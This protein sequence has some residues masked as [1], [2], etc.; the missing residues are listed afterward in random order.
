MN[1]LEVVPSPA[2]ARK[3]KHLTSMMNIHVD[4][5]VMELAK[6]DIF[7]SRSF[8]NSLPTAFSNIIDRKYESVVSFAADTDWR[9]MIMVEQSSEFYQSAFLAA[10]ASGIT[11]IVLV[12]P[13]RKAK[14]F[15]IMDRMLTL[16]NVDYQLVD[17]RFSG[18]N[19]D[20]LVVSP[21]KITSEVI[22][23]TR[24]GIFV[25]LATPATSSSTLD[26]MFGIKQPNNP[27]IEY[28]AIGMEFQHLI[29]GVAMDD[30]TPHV[31]F[32]ADRTKGSGWS[33]TREF[34]NIFSALFPE[35]EM[36]SFFDAYQN[37]TNS[38]VLMKSG[39]LLTSPDRF[40]TVLNINTDLLK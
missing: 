4:D 38:N 20:V 8:F 18:V 12:L 15:T 31:Y 25:S 7:D 23:H 17:D 30:C 13:D 9:C 22:K 39:F 3:I 34:Q 36:G 2:N 29:I 11:P 19:K 10:K 14:A 40:A 24:S 35:Y 32:S 21:D 1:V 6:L 33:A 16:C 5:V 26:S 28:D 27:T 37:N